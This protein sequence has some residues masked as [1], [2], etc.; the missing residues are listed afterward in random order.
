[1]VDYIQQ[2]WA[3]KT[4]YMQA[5]LLLSQ[6]QGVII[7]DVRNRHD[8]TQRELAALLAVNHTYVSKL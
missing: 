5:K 1:M 2:Y 3:A 7:K 6:H 4:V 8:L